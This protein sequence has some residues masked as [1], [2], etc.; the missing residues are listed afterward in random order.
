MN[1]D[2]IA[3]I[4]I[5]II[6]TLIAIFVTIISKEEEII[7]EQNNLMRID[8]NITEEYEEEIQYVEKID[9]SQYSFMEKVV[10]QEKYLWKQFIVTAY[11][12]CIKCCGK[13]NGITASGKQATQGITIATSKQYAFGTKMEIQGY[14]IYEVQDRGGAIQGDKIDIFFNSHDEALKFGR[15]TLL[16]RVVK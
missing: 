14:G 16:A 10:S 11:C 15:R 6:L 8:T 2:D 1:K 3:T 12:P 5:L 13:T 9:Y 7:V 4:I